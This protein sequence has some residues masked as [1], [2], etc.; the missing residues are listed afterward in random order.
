M[1][2]AP[3]SKVVVPLAYEQR[4]DAAAAAV[5]RRLLGVIEGNRDG[6]IA[7]A[8]SE[9]LHR[10]R[11]S[12]RR[13]RTVQRQLAGV[14]PGLELPGFRSEFRWLQRATGEARDLDVY[15]LGFEDMQTL[16]S[17]QVGS[18]LAPLRQVLEHW[19]LTAHFQMAKA[20]AS[21]RSDELLTDWE[22][23]LESLVEMPTED[24]PDATT[25][26]GQLAGKRIH[27]VYKRVVRMGR[28]IDQCSLPEAYHEL[29][30]TGKELRYMLELFGTQLHP[31]EVVD[32]MVRSLKA[33]QDVLGR[34]QDR[35]VQIT[36]LRSLADEVGSLPRGPR[37]LMAMGVLVDRLRAD[38][39][40]ARGEFAERFAALASDEQRRLV[41]ETFG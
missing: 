17:E 6:A 35:E 16:V 19:R 32:Q 18:D 12:V 39:A 21:R 10:L 8:D 9:F 23:L 34:H 29:R 4:G 22:M 26:I 27:R 20:I 1:S 25:P 41:A 30:K 14:F 31:T 15:L 5:L 40:A 11:I 13:S 36:M 3:T 38:E 7:D 2:A 28:T 33:L 37:A 24:R